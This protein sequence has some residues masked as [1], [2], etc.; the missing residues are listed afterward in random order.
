M[1]DTHSASP[2]RGDARGGAL[3]AMRELF[4]SA[5]E[6]WVDLSTGI[7]PWPWSATGWGDAPYRLP[8]ETDRQ[9][10][11]AAMASAFGAPEQSI[12][13]GPGSELL[14]HLLPALLRPK[15]VAV[16]S[17][18]YADHAH[19]WRTSGCHVIETPTPLAEARS[20]DMVVICNPNNP[21]GTRF[22]PDA[23]EVARR[24]LRKH[25]G[26]LVVD[27]AFADLT[28]EIS[29]A[30]RAVS[31]NLIVLRSAGK[32]YGLAGLRLGALLG[33]P[34]L[35]DRLAAH[36]GVWRVSTP[37]LTIG[38]AAYEDCAWQTATRQ[39]L[40]KARERLDHLLAQTE[41][42]VMGGT[43]LFRYVE[44]SD[45]DKVWNRLAEHGV[46]VRRFS[47]TNQHLRIG[48]PKDAT[49]ETRLLDALRG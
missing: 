41:Y 11:V 15:Q 27:E 28:P 29:S 39:R 30:P 3:D 42:H 38:A 16:L 7:N 34:K 20:C 33:P 25:S 6:P 32:F 47:W 49:A 44:V 5:P 48:L 37:A 21:D 26:W 14:I 36:M 2:H 40:A 9:G 22:D 10:C 43:D 17:P 8:T 19:V 12:L 24:H 35:L 31:G 13:V 4:P 23:I 46:Y 1:S 45:A 18:T